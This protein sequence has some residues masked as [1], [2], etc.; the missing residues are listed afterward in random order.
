MPKDKKTKTS[1]RK[2]E[3]SHQKTGREGEA[4]ACDFLIKKGY[5]ILETNYRYK[6]SE[7]D[8]IAKKEQLL[9]FIE[10][11]T[12]SYSSFGYPEE[13]VNTRKAQKVIEGAENYI[14]ELNWEK[15]IRFDIIAIDNSTNEILHLEDAFY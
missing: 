14:Y 1:S 4:A 5:E 3:A 10:V 7:I 15:N 11:K 6:K 2:Q 8:I 13:A 12:K 9:V